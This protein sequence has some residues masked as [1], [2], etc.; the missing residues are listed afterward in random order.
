[1]LPWANRVLSQFAK[2]YKRLNQ[3]CFFGLPFFGGHRSAQFRVGSWPAVI[4]AFAGR[5]TYQFWL[6]LS[7]Q[8]PLGPA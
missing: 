2:I 3:M 7:S 6:R 8:W 5:S 4:F 1:L